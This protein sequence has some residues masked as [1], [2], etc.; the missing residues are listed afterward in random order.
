MEF[1]D[2]FVGTICLLSALTVPSV[3]LA[4][5]DDDDDDGGGGSPVAEI[6]VQ[7]D[8]GDSINE[9]LSLAPGYARWTVIVQGVCTEVVFIAADNVTVKGDPVIGGRVEGRFTVDGARRV[10]IEDLTISGSDR[11]IRVNFGAY[12][13]I[14]NVT[15]ENMSRTG[16][17]AFNGGIASVE[18]ST[19][20]GPTED[21][22]V[23]VEG[24]VL[25]IR[26]SIIDG[27]DFG[28]SVS[29]GATLNLET[30]II[31]GATLDGLQMSS[32]SSARLVDNEITDVARN[33]INIV[34]N[35]F[36]R[37][38]NSTL[39]ASNPR[40]EA[41]LLDGGSIR[42]EGG[43]TVTGLNG[44][45]S[46]RA[47]NGSIVRQFIGLGDGPDVLNGEVRTRRLSY[48]GFGDARING[49]VRVEWKSFV[50]L[51]GNEADD[52]VIIGDVLVSEDSQIL[53]SSFGPRIS[54]NLLC[55][56]DESSLSDDSEMASVSGT[57]D[58]TGFD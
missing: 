27:A 34:Q 28:I 57:I 25:D 2:L 42:L 1:R 18:G 8:R 50:D 5:D 47:R 43:N 48:A 30:S 54:G 12:V 58:C 20:L 53:L 13:R 3:A 45:L 39:I 22:I 32:G 15:I 16:I 46:I 56:D 9:A 26:N 41:I 14:T 29:N 52:V 35:A 6:L 17:F 10:R 37:I 38:R 55:F 7:C 49:G 23:A 4:D 36:V 19:I 33:P 21:G 40:E 31:K 44:G 24:A 51:S 11:G